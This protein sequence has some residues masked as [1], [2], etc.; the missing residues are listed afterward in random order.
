MHI[1]VEDVCNGDQSCSV[2]KGSV[3]MAEFL[4]QYG[5]QE[6]CH[7]A[8]VASRWPQGFRCPCCGDDRHTTFIRQNRQYWQCFRCRYQTTV[9]AGTIFEATKLPLTRWFLAMHLITQAKNNVSALELKRHL[10]VRY[11]TAW[12]MKH[13]LLQVMAERE[14]R[15]VLDGRVEIDDA[16]LGGEKPGKAGRGSENKIPFIVAVQTTDDGQPLL[17]CMSRISFTKEAMET[18]ANKSLAASARVVSDG[19]NCFKGIAGDVESHTAIVVGSGRQG[20]TRPEFRR[21]NTVLSNLKTAISG[22]YHA[23]KFDK[24][25]H[26]YLAEVQYRFN[27]RFNLGSIL[28]RLVRAAAV[29]WPRPESMIRLAEV[30]G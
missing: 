24:Y 12:L 27:R 5:T 23:F 7:A 16:Y 18:W 10:G 13:K 30:G 6:K 19:L 22:T 17:A 11:K 28:H 1:F 2:S 9:T 29:T 3:S 8:L 25:V 4:D 21:V 26:R 15:R 14:D 20:V